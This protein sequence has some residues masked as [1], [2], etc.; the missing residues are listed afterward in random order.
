MSTATQA[1]LYQFPI[2]PL[3]AQVRQ[4]LHYKGVEFT[5]VEQPLDAGSPIV[6]TLTLAGGET[7]TD[8]EPIAL[9]LEELYPEPTILPPDLRGVQI[10]LAR[11]IDLEIGDALMRLALPDE[12]AFFRRLGAESEARLRLVRERKFGAGFCDRMERES[13]ANLARAAALLAPFEEALA[14]KAFILG[15][16]GLCDFALYGQLHNLALS[17]QL[18][19]PRE[20]SNLQAFHG[21]L[22]RISSTLDDLGD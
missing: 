4:L 8:A 11:Y 2:S 13:A 19:I 20:F 21:R 5:T 3:C 10:A 17:G 6:P 18:K 22:D 14:G 9:R 1:T 16:I 15:R 7:I 12:L